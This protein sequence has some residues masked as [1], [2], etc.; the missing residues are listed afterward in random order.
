MS[1]MAAFDLVRQENQI[2]V[3]GVL[4]VTEYV[5]VVTKIEKYASW[6]DLFEDHQFADEDEAS[7][8]AHPYT[9]VG[10]GGN[11][12]PLIRARHIIALD[13]DGN[14]IDS[15]PALRD[16]LSQSAKYV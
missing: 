16:F 8:S 13:F 15:E 12:A 3:G 7:V 1:K 10:A 5:D 2:E 4:F 9:A 11:F 6:D 14:P